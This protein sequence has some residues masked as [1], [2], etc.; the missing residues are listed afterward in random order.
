MNLFIFNVVFVLSLPFL[1]LIEVSC[2]WGFLQIQI[3]LV[4][5]TYQCMDG[6]RSISYFP[7]FYLLSMPNVSSC[8]QACHLVCTY[9]TLAVGYCKGPALLPDPSYPNSSCW[10]WVCS[11]RWIDKPSEHTFMDQPY[12]YITTF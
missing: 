4:V 11:S 1:V 7:Y 3:Y 2:S 9:H 6:R 8:I 12:I 5:D 10:Y